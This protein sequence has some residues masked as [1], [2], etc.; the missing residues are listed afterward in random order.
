M[1][2]AEANICVPWPWNSEVCS[3]RIFSFVDNPN[4]TQRAHARLQPFQ[5]EGKMRR[6]LLLHD[7]HLATCI[8][9]ICIIVI[10]LN[11][12]VLFGP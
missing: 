8:P 4:S 11:L 5:S 3:H 7:P 12:P 9:S 10:I 6:S 2:A 1:R